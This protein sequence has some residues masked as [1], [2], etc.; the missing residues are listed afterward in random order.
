MLLQLLPKIDTGPAESIHPGPLRCTERYSSPVWSV[1][2]I[3]V[4]SG[5]FRQ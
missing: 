3:V 4:D 1:Y 2:I 5:R